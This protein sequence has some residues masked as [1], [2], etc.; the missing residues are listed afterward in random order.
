MLSFS[1]FY[2]EDLGRAI[3]R[4]AK[5][6]FTASLA[7]ADVAPVVEA[8]NQGIDSRLEACYLPARGDCFKLDGNRLDV[9][10]S[11]ES[12]PV[13]VRRLLEAGDES[14]IASGI[15]QTLGIELV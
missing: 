4:L 6:P 15:C 14:G 1:A 2:T 13:L 3:A 8:V 10:L 9:T 5:E 11:R 7:G 12:L